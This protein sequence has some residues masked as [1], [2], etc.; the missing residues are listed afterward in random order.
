MKQG[1]IEQCQ[2]IARM[3]HDGPKETVLDGQSK[4]AGRRVT[5]LSL[6]EQSKGLLNY[7]KN[8]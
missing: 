7:Y 5:D 3:Y 6:P 2:R 4:H 8:T 1:R